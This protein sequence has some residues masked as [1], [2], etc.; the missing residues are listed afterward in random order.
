MIKKNMY[1]YEIIV[2]F[3][4]SLFLIKRVHADLPGFLIESSKAKKEYITKVENNPKMSEKH[5]SELRHQMSEKSKTEFKKDF[6][7]TYVSGIKIVREIGLSMFKDLWNSTVSANESEELDEKQ[8]TDSRMA[9]LPKNTKDR[10]PSSSV[11]SSSSSSSRINST[12]NG[13]PVQSGGAG[14]ISFSR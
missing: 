10:K 3:L 1:L 9:S 5:K 14:S 13:E 11:S 4:I 12:T 2:F 8:I 6:M 7:A